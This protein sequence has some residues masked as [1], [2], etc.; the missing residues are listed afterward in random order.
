M[1]DDE[2]VETIKRQLQDHEKR[3]SALEILSQTKPE[4]A[5]TGLSIKDFIRLKEPKDD[6]QKTLAIGYHLEHYGGYSSFN[7][8]DLAKGFREAKE[9]VPQNINDKVNKNID[10]NY[11]MEAEKKKD[12]KKAWVLTAKGEEYVES[13]F[14]EKK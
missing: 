14:Q 6:L 11:I 7:T 13:G 2:I 12:G 10:K 3:I 4:L 9:P 5:G 1:H 8:K